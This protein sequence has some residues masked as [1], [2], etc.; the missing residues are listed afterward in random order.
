MRVTVVYGY[1][2]H[3][4]HH[5]EHDV[6]V[7]HTQLILSRDCSG[8]SCMQDLWYHSLH[9]SHRIM[10]IHLSLGIYTTDT[11]HSFLNHFLELIPRRNT[12]CAGLG[13][14]VNQ[15]VLNQVESHS[16][17]I[18]NERRGSFP[19]TISVA[20]ATAKT[21]QSEAL[22]CRWPFERLSNRLVTSRM[23]IPVSVFLFVD[24]T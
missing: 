22:G 3:S 2:C 24:L 1:S 7:W 9:I 13:K 6:L 19:C 5:C 14:T 8:S 21:P 17:N 10:A 18:P 15:S 16:W 4:S 11:K 23:N 20:T 12:P